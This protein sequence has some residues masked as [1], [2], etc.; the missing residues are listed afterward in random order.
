MPIVK[1]D[2]LSAPSERLGGPIGN[3]EMEGTETEGGFAMGTQSAKNIEQ[4]GSRRVAE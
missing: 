2:R 1:N 4:I 3:E